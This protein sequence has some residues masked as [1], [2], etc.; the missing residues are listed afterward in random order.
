MI[1]YGS[2]ALTRAEK[3]YATTKKELLA[4]VAFTKHFKHYLLGWQF[5]LRTNHNSLHWLHGF[6]QPEGQIARWLK[7]LAPFDYQ[8]VH[9]PGKLHRNADALS[10]QVTKGVQPSAPL[11]LQVSVPAEPEDS[12]PGQS[13]EPEDSSPDQ[14]QAQDRPAE[15]QL[16]GEV[17]LQTTAEPSGPKWDWKQAQECDPEVTRVRS[18]REKSDQVAREFKADANLRP[19]W[20]IWNTLAVRDGILVSLMGNGPGLGE[21]GLVVVPSALVPEIL[22]EFHNTRVGGHLGMAKLKKKNQN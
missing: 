16:E 4:V 22:H 19:Y 10:R 21:Y 3:N 9:R 18:W 6:D 11:A 14:R 7:Q 12:S 5:V 20:N 2:R 17:Q 1:A 13:A 15:L 8:I